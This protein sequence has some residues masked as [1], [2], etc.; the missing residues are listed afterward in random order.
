MKPKRTF[1]DKQYAKN[2]RYRR[3]LERFE[4]AGTCPFCPEQFPLLR[5]PIL[6]KAGQWFV[7]W[8][9]HKYKNSRRHLL[10][11]S[12]QHKESLQDLSPRDLADVIRLV[13][14]LAKTY[15]IRGGGLFLRFGDTRFTGATVKHLHFH[16]VV[17]KLTQTR[18]KAEPVYV[19]IG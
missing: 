1:I 6:H 8:N 11:V 12:R 13:R 14:R 17:P 16:L 15:A 7:V 18:D 10:I 3:Q 4:R 9:T 2:P 5:K 19:P